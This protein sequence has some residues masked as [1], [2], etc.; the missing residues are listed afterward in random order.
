M[1]VASNFKQQTAMLA[2][3]CTICLNTHH[4]MWYMIVSKYY[5]RDSL[6]KNKYVDM[7]LSEVITSIGSSFIKSDWKWIQLRKSFK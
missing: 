3:V 2:M 5:I 6:L 1:A 7:Q 4:N